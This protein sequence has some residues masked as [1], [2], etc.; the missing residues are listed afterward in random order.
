MSADSCFDQL[1]ADA[2]DG[3][4]VALGKVLVAHYDA[5]AE[6]VRHVLNGQTGQGVTIEDLVQQTY[7]QAIRGIGS[8]QQRDE[9]SFSAWLLT[10]A[11][12][13]TLNELR[14]RQRLKRG[15]DRHVLAIPADGAASS[16][17]NLVSLVSDPHPSPGRQL[18]EGDAVRAIQLGIAALPEEQRAAVNLHHLAG[19]SVEETAAE[20]QRTP[21]A[22]RGLLQRARDSLR[23]AMGNSSRWFDKKS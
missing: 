16:L 7:V 8:L 23:V 9:A 10:I 4:F 18:A 22:V 12:H 2:V 15:G 1:L 20:L 21:G 17:T 5:I 19:K 6:R 3:N 14:R 13:E 11:E